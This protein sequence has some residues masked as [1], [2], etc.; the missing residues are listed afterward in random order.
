[1]SHAA[2]ITRIHEVLALQAQRQPN[3]ICLYEEGGGILTYA[4]LWQRVQA[5]AGWLGD[6]GIQ[7]G[8][9]VMMAG[10]NCAAMIAALFGCSMAGAW[11][12]GVNARL[13][14]R[15]VDNI[16]QHAQPELL[17]YTT[18]IS[19]AAATHADA[20]GALDADPA[21]WGP[22][23]Q[24]A[25]AERP[26]QA[27]TGS[28]AAE[29]ATVIYTSGTTGAPKGVLVPHR[30]LLHFARVSAASRRLTPHD[31]GYAALPMSHI[32]GI[33]TVLMATV[34][35]GASLVL[36][37]RFDAE[38][39]FKALAHPGVSILQGVPT[40]FSRMMAVAPP[41]ASLAAPALRY[42]YTGGAAL[43]PTLKRDAERYFGVP[44]HHGY[45][46][47]E[48]AGSMFIT[49]IDAP[50]DDCSAGYAVDGVEFRIGSPDNGAPT[51]GERGDILI[52]GP[53]V[54]LGYYRSPE[55]TAQA[56]LPGGWLNTG[57]IGFVDQS[58]ALFIAGRSKDL[59]IRSGFNVYPIEVESVINAFPGV[60]LSA[61]VGRNTPDQN[62]EVIAFVEPLPGATI[63]THLLMLHL[64]A[65]LAPYKRPAQIIPIETIPTTVSGKILKQPLKE[66]LA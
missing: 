11:L 17:L 41:R 27:D 64:R 28:H 15:E 46:I 9:R 19:P 12:V 51:P 66:R 5:V 22:G 44:M 53:G 23:V 25:R 54:M 24:A 20:A 7:P 37:S 8:H 45:G 65:Q 36:R 34:Y 52:R 55:Q 26:T 3:A 4:Q 59:I 16:R 39:A 35:A 30:G 63:D 48:Y 10:E 13:S 40:M 58:G 29:V 60:R 18:G 21:V 49:D 56:I 47:T 43:D 31:I 2:P 1:M 57:D 33:A 50:R 38:D 42:V 14:E 61:V 32:F 6:Q 62:E